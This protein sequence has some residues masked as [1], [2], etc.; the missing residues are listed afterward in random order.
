M[1][2]APPAA[3]SPEGPTKPGPGR[4][5]PR[6]EYLAWVWAYPVFYTIFGVVFVLLTR[7][8]PPPNPAWSMHHILA[9]FHDHALTMKIGFAILMG[10]IGLSA[11]ANG[12]V[13]IQ[14][15]RMSVRPVFSY[16]YVASLSVGAIPGCL[17]VAVCFVT[18]TLRPD[19][20]PH[21]IVMLYQLGMLS[22]VG[23]LGCFT[24]NY[25]ILAL[26][27]LLDRNKVF[28]TWFAYVSIWQVVTEV[29]AAPVFLFKEGPFA[30]NGEISFYEAT[31][32]Y[33]VFLP[34]LILVLRAAVRRVATQTDD[35]LQAD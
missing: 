25:I 9:F 6:V 32:I 33:C 5:H 30:W 11:L 13:A 8:M 22:F 1:K 34:C 29:L 14:I 31:L 3:T 12:L 16:A 26:A 27:I 17:L 15:K 35:P 7:V 19:R 21:L 18:A 4:P 24:T 20:D 23:S 10:T 28:P 2:A